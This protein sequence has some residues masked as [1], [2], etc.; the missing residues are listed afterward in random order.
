MSF[1]SRLRDAN[2]A[3]Q[4]EWDINSRID[5]H[6][7]CCELAGEMGEACNIIK[8]IER[9]RLGLRGTKAGVDLLADELADVLICIDL[10]AMDLR[11]SDLDARSARGAGK[12]L[13]NLGSVLAFRVG[14]V[15]HF[16]GTV[17]LGRAVARTIISDAIGA[18]LRLATESGVDI[19]EATERKFNETSVKYGLHTRF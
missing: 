5:V 8:K 9:E 6:Y 17:Q 18:V 13:T 2:V 1:M 14:Q 16:I 10:I 12:S 4:A 19:E 11:I 3:R 7:R 15:C